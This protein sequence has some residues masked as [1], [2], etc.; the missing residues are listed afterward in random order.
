MERWI[1]TRQAGQVTGVDASTIR[2]W[3]D[4]GRLRAQVLYIGERPLIRIRESDL[5]AFLD[6]Y[7]EDP[8][9]E[10]GDEG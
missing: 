9:N 5:R 2:R 8:S 4:A 7:S 1:S 3:I 10:T 6:Y